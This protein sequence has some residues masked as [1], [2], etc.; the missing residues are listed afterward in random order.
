MIPES[1]AIHPVTESVKQ[2]ALRKEVTGTSIFCH[3][4][5]AGSLK[6]KTARWHRARKRK[7]WYLNFCPIACMYKNKGTILI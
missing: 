1:P 6:G 5:W 7:K 4:P 3:V 2:T